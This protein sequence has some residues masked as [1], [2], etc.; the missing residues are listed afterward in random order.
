M[1]LSVK[2]LIGL[3]GCH[4]STRARAAL[5]EVHANKH[6]NAIVCHDNIREMFFGEYRFDKSFE[7]I[8]SRLAHDSMKYLLWAG[9][10][11]IIDDT[12]IAL[13]ECQRSGLIKGLRAY[14]HKVGRLS[15]EAIQFTKPL[16]DCL[17]TRIENH[18]GLGPQHWIDAIGRIAEGYRPITNLGQALLEG[19]DSLEFVS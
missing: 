10:N 19:F 15:I 14:E 17:K 2:V 12:L 4:K 13:N 5:A 18:R 1:N 9:K 16:A 11:L 3:P 6:Q 7:D 8:V